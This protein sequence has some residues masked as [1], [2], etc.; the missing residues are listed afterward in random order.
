MYIIDRNQA[1]RANT[2]EFSE[3]VL[4]QDMARKALMILVPLAALGSLL[5]AWAL[6]LGASPLALAVAFV[7]ILAAFSGRKK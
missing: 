1:E 7:F 2:S 4:S 3:E 5:I 6:L